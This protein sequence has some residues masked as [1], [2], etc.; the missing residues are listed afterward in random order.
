M[1]YMNVSDEVSKSRSVWQNQY[2]RELFSLERVEKRIESFKT[3]TI[4]VIDVLKQQKR[5]VE[6][7]VICS[8][9]NAL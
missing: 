8:V 2:C 7:N 9:K 6:V 5:V 4:P 1:F 3:D